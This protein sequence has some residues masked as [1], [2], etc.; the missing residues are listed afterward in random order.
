[1]V[2]ELGKDIFRCTVSV[3]GCLRM[4]T[5]TRD[6]VE[7]PS[8]ATVNQGAQDTP[9]T[10]RQSGKEGGRREGGGGR[11]GNNYKTIAEIIYIL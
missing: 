3:L 5:S 6:T 1:M 7:G 11:D 2:V 8:K 9:P 10:Y 4:W